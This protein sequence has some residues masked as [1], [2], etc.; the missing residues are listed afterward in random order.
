MKNTVVF[1]A[2]IGVGVLALIAGIVIFAGVTGH[3]PARGEAGIAVGIVLIAAGAVGWFL[4]KPK[5][6]A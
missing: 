4:T 1:Y 2:L 3:H 6:V 5:A